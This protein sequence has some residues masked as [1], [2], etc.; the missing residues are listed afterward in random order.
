VMNARKTSVFFRWTTKIGTNRLSA[1]DIVVM[2]R[3]LFSE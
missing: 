1:I 3:M 2:E